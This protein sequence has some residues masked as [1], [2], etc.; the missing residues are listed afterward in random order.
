[1]RLI[2]L[3]VSPG[4]GASKPSGQGVA[5]PG[6]AVGDGLLG[7]AGARAVLAGLGDSLLFLLKR[8]NAK[9]ECAV[10]GDAK[11]VRG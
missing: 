2:L 4:E 1:M 3:V 9:A 7:R 11:S 10:K 8:E 6:D 5:A